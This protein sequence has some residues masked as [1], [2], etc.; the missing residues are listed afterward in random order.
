MEPLPNE[1]AAVEAAAA[2]FGQQANKKMANSRPGNRRSWETGM[3]D[4]ATLRLEDYTLL[5]LGGVIMN[6][7]IFEK[8]PSPISTWI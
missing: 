5:S 7:A 8:Y 3:T 4:M 6:T 2:Q 1:V